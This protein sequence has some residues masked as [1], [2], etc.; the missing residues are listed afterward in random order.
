MR[1]IPFKKVL[2]LRSQWWFVPPDQYS[3]APL[4]TPE[5]WWISSVYNPCSASC[6]SRRLVNWSSWLCPQPS[7]TRELYILHIYKLVLH[8]SCYWFL[9]HLTTMEVALSTRASR[10]SLLSNW[11][12]PPM[13]FHCCRDHLGFKILIL[14]LWVPFYDKT[15]PFFLQVR[16]SKI[17][18]KKEHGSS[19]KLGYV[20]WVDF[21]DPDICIWPCSH[22]GAFFMLNWSFHPNV[23]SIHLTLAHSVMHSRRQQILGKEKKR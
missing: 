5:K 23:V 22:A 6:A 16:S 11:C 21:S 8:G 10:S 18:R 9:I 19:D 7:R 4:F 1:S 2:S 12:I 20:V 3:G 15:C 17:P 13:I 14:H